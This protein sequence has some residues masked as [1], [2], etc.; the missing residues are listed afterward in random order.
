MPKCITMHSG[1]I[2]IKC[3]EANRLGTTAT[4]KK[5]KRLIAI[6][7]KRRGHPMACRTTQRSTWVSQEQRREEE[8]MRQSNYG[9]GVLRGGMGKYTVDS[10]GS[11]S[12]NNF[13]MF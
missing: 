5:K 1:L 7:P 12:L 8:I 13:N 2:L 3:G 9:V 4:E 11:H 10:L 6:V